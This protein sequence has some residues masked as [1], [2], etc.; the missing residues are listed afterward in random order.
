MVRLHH[1]QRRRPYDLKAPPFPHVH[2]VRS[3]ARAQRG[4]LAVAP[5]GARASPV[6]EGRRSGRTLPGGLRAPPRSRTLARGSRAPFL[7]LAGVVTGCTSTQSVSSDTA[8][9]ARANQ[10]LAGRT[11]TLHLSDGR[12]VAA[13]SLRLA[14][15][16]T[17]W[18][19][20]ATGALQRAATADVRVAERVRRGRGAWQGALI[21]GLGTAVVMSAIVAT[22]VQDSDWGACG[23]D[24]F[25]LNCAKP[26]F[27][28]GIR[29]DSRSSDDDPRRHRGRGHRFRRPSHAPAPRLPASRER[30]ELLP[31]PPTPA[32]VL[33]GRHR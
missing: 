2:D 9:L 33:A 11:V 18:I 7:L 8:G 27:A 6:E 29:Y 13:Q 1:G 28:I 17:S 12:R 15:D 5:T 19:D 16:T 31:P 3:R 30:L 14:P 22:D 10:T 23:D 32:P 20:P 4:R 26:L 21:T 24:S 25:G